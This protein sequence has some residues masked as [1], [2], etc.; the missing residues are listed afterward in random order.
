M[1][2]STRAVEPDDIPHGPCERHARGHRVMAR[3]RLLPLTRARAE[4][5]CLVLARSAG[6]H[7]GH[8][9]KPRSDVRAGRCSGALWSHPAK[10]ILCK[11]VHRPHAV[12]TP[13]AR[14]FARLAAKPGG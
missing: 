10:R 5:T 4:L 9:A 11:P 12:A 14:Y 13:G 6:K 3:Y 1:D 7:H 8:V 2:A